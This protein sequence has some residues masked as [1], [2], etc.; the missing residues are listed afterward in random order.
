MEWALTGPG[1]AQFT[2]DAEDTRIQIGTTYLSDGLASVL[3]MAVDL[4]LGAGATSAVLVGEPGGHR[5]FCSGATDSVFVQVVRFSDL[6][7]PDTWWKD[8]DLEWHGIV[9]VADVVDSTRAMAT[10]VLQQHGG[11]GYRQKWGMPFPMEEYA[12][13]QQT[14]NTETRTH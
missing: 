10:E 5:I 3:G 1:S 11:E 4:S 8:A 14:G 9:A 13:L 6:G 12:Q 7:S 2:W